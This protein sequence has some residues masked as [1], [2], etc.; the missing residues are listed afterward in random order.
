MKPQKKIFISLIA[1]AVLGFGIIYENSDTSALNDP[2]SANQP[3]T[4]QLNN[5]YSSPH[6]QPPP[7][8]K[9]SINRKEVLQRNVKGYRE[10]TYWGNEHLIDH[11][12]ENFNDKEF[13]DFIENEV[14]SKDIDV[15]W[16]AEY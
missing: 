12:T 11:R 4:T 1:L 3:Q 7:L 16:G 13:S 8:G 9:I 10:Q 15:Y 6:T 14:K 2:S 5:F